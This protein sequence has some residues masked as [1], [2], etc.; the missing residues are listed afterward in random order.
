MSTNIFTKGVFTKIGNTFFSSKV[1]KFLIVERKKTTPNKPKNFIIAKT[2]EK[3]YY[4]SS[5]YSTDIE[6][7]FNV[8]YQGHKYLLIVKP[9]K[10]EVLNRSHS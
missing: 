8:D 5:L 2:K 6:D 4:I 7:Q 3:E 1:V 9:D 10:V